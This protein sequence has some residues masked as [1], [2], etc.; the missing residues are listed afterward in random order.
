[1]PVGFLTEEHRR[2]YGRYAA[3]PS[4]EQLARF[5]H[6]D[7]GDLALIC[8]RRG[9]HN[10]LGFA[11]QLCTAR[12]LGTFLADPTDVPK[13]AVGYVAPQVATAEGHPLPPLDRAH[14]RDALR[15]GLLLCP[16]QIH[17][18]VALPRPV[19]AHVP[20]IPETPV[21]QHAE[22]GLS[23]QGLDGPA[24]VRGPT[25]PDPRDHEVAAS[26][27]YLGHVGA[28]EAEPEAKIRVRDRVVRLP[29][30]PARE[31]ALGRHHSLLPDQHLERPLQ[32]RL[33]DARAPL[34]RGEGPL[35]GADGR[36]HLP[37]PGLLRELRR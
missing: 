10:R 13:G 16:D 21:G 25:L 24:T 3:E 6:L 14:E 7:D 4:P 19:P 12:F 2:S 17:L 26:A 32:G 30:G 36:E 29:R 33:V 28:D 9:G 23:N 11:L 18:H 22:D 27:L 15:A 1:M 37:G 8:R 35:A 5:F 20:R 34:Y 31:R